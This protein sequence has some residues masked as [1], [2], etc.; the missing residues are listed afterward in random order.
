MIEE[1]DEYSQALRRETLGAMNETLVRIAM[2]KPP[3]FIIGGEDYPY[4]R[5]W[6]LLK[7]AERASVYLHQILR[8]DDDRALHDHP[9]PST[10]IILEGELREHTADSARLLTPGSITTREA[11]DAHRLEVVDGPVW[12]LFITGP[13]VRDWGFHCPQGWIPWW[14]FVD[15]DDPGRPGPG[16]GG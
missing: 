4:I 5:R 11:E 8:D 16:C 12:S 1:S 10:S 7:D 9:W 2:V 14:E 15:P 6:Y 13:K 3:D